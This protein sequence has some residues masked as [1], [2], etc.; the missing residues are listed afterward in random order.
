M[1]SQLDWDP[2]FQPLSVL[3][4]LEGFKFRQLVTFNNNKNRTNF[5][6][7]VVALGA[8]LDGDWYRFPPGD[9]HG[10]KF[11]EAVQTAWDTSGQVF[12]LLP[13][14]KPK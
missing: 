13:K 14:S 4:Y 6:S 10:N 9:R 3:F 7:S 11:N 8:T 12:D 5:I 2:V 1:S